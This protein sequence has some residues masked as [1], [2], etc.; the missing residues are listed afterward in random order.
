MKY[1]VAVSPIARVDANHIYAWLHELS[2][3]GAAAWLEAF[4]DAVDGLAEGALL[5]GRASEGRSLGRDVRENFF[6]TKRGKRY[7]LLY[8]ID[9]DDVRVLRVRGP[10]Q[11]PLRRRDLQ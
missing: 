6:K 10:G 2:P 4:Q 1:R 9:G 3:M 7:R 5:H 8:R 11:P